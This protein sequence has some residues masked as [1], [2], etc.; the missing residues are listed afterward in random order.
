MFQ[1]GNHTLALTRV[2]DTQSGQGGQS[3]GQAFA[4]DLGNWRLPLLDT[5]LTTDQGGLTPL[6]AVAPWVEGARLWLQVPASLGTALGSGPASAAIQYLSFT[7]ST[8]STPVA[9]TI[10]STSGAPAV[11]RPVFT[12]DA[13]N[14]WT[15]QAS[16]AID[17]GDGANDFI[18]TVALQRQGKRLLDQTTGLAW[19]P[20]GYVLSGPDGTRLRL[21][22]QGKVQSIRFADGEQWLVSDAGVALIAGT[23]VGNA[24]PG[25]AH[26]VRAQRAR[27]HHAGQRPRSHSGSRSG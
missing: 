19:V 22:A 7:L 16:E 13:A 17:A 20:Q 5:H 11:V 27:P 15:L 8:T 2:L 23:G 9:S 26:R 12:N 18:A 6:G 1:L 4:S 24:T 10:G 25:P 21:D 14:G 3:G